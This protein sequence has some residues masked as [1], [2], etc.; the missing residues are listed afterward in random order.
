MEKI[1][2]VEVIWARKSLKSGKAASPSK[3][4]IEKFLSAGDVGTKILL[5]VFINIMKD[6]TPPEKW[7]MS[8]TTPLF[9]VEVMPLGVINI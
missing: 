8:I 5:S 2:K 3:A 6:C 4:T 1:F 7:S 9:K